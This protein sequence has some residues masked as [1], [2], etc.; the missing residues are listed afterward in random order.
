MARIKLTQF[1]GQNMAVNPALL[2]DT[3]GTI[4]IDQDTEY[5]DM[6]PG[7]V[8]SMVLTYTAQKKTIY[9]LVDRDSG[10]NIWHAWDGIV[11]IVE[12]PNNPY[13]TNRFFY[14]DGFYPKWSDS[15]NTIYKF[16]V[17]APTVAP[18]VGI[19]PNSPS[20]TQE[21]VYFVFT[22][23]TARGEESAPSPVST[24]QVFDSNDR[25]T[26]TF[27]D[28]L[29][30]S[31]GVTYRRVY[32]T[33]SNGNNAEFFFAV[34]QGISESSIY[35]P[36]Y[37]LWPTGGILPSATWLP[38]PNELTCLTAMWNGMLAGIYK[39]KVRFC[40]AYVPYAWPVAYEIFPIDV[41]AV[42]L[43]VFG[44]NLLVL[45]DGK[46]IVV[47]GSSPD[48]LIE[49][50]VEFLQPCVSV[51]SIASTGYGVIYAS[52]E[53]LAYV[54]SDGARLLTEGVIQKDDWAASVPENVRGVF[55]KGKYVFCGNNLGTETNLGFVLDP[56]NH[57]AIYAKR[58]YYSSY[59][60]VDKDDN[61]LYRLA[62]TR[63]IYTVGTGN[64]KN[65]CSFRSKLFSLDKPIPA[66]A[67]GQVIA[68]EYPVTFKLIRPSQPAATRTTAYSVINSKPFRLAGGYMDTDFYLEIST[69]YPV[70]SVAVAHNIAELAQ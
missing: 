14:T 25:V 4:S 69:N 58:F 62:L 68:D 45:T 34:D 30:Q 32:R 44:Q 12:D 13:N 9:R 5:V 52:K 42:G 33:I 28:T 11:H 53:G 15:N 1:K 35:T 23:V 19:T 55:H 66:F 40:E 2:V 29:P 54:G 67:W 27:N 64:D 22:Y 8:D 63:G 41:Q 60:Y 65:T 16:G 21:T 38:P 10:A 61:N 48:S 51:Q 50:P 20:G 57:S 37:N 17:P 46:P 24:A 49:S 36:Y 59:L 56:K 31:R 43:A 18:Q 6:R 47:T 26:I 7:K 70:R 3:I 39:G